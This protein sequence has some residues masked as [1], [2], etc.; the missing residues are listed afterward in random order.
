MAYK[1]KPKVKVGVRKKGN[2]D[3]CKLSDN[4]S[5]FIPKKGLNN[6]RM[7]SKVKGGVNSS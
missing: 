1:H 7:L 5:F 4:I 6:I 3:F 2:K